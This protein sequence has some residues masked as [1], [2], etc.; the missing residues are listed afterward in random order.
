MQAFG[1]SYLLSEPD[2]LLSGML[3]CRHPGMQDCQSAQRPV[4]PGLPVCRAAC[5]PIFEF[6]LLAG[7]VR[8]RDQCS[9]GR[10]RQAPEGG[11]GGRADLSAFTYAG[12]L[13]CRNAGLPV[14]P[15]A[16]FPPSA[17]Q[18]GFHVCAFAGRTP[19]QGLSAYIGRHQGREVA[20]PA[21]GP[22]SDGDEEGAFWS[23]T[24]LVLCE[25]QESPGPRVLLVGR[26]GGAS[27]ASH[28]LAMTDLSL[29]HAPES[30]REGPCSLVL[31]SIEPSGSVRPQ[32]LRRLFSGRQPVSPV[33]GRGG[34]FAGGY[35][36]QSYP[37]L[38]HCKL[39]A[40]FLRSRISAR[41][42]DSA[43]TH[44]GRGGAPVWSLS[45]G[46]ESVCAR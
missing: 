33:S 19:N 9:I 41:Q 45:A 27:A 6:C 24:E 3:D 44:P 29:V 23:R 46:M 36:F 5:N 31:G 11:W 38:S 39:E 30:G 40:S 10:C 32:P 43:N 8:T 25:P 15:A 42:D 37:P 14:C 21:P 26:A 35:S 16:G 12:L 2:C 7:R 17:V 13:A 34:C 4:S 22:S 28:G 1:P 20:S 18:S